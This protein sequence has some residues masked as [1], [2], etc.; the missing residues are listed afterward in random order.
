MIKPM[1]S[2]KAFATNSLNQ[3][4][5]YDVWFHSQIVCSNVRLPC[6]LTIRCPSV[7]RAPLKIYSAVCR[8]IIQ[9]RTSITRGEQMEISFCGHEPI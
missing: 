2:S 6:I 8:L 9:G 5:L 7:H 1:L 3:T 4:F